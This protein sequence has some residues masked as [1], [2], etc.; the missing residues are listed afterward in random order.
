MTVAFYLHKPVPVILSD[1]LVTYSTDTTGFSPSSQDFSNFSPDRAA[2]LCS[3][4]Y[5]IDRETMFA[6]AGSEKDI[7]TFASSIPGEW[8]RRTKYERPVHG[9]REVDY[10]LNGADGPHG[11]NCEV[12]VA[13]EC[14][15]DE[16]FFINSYASRG[17]NH[18]IDTT[19]FGTCSAIGSGGDAIRQ[20]VEQEDKHVHHAPRSEI[21]DA[22]TILGRLN[23]RKLFGKLEYPEKE[24]WGGIMEAHYKPPGQNWQ[25]PPTFL[26]V[27]LC[28]EGEKLRFIGMDHKMIIHTQHVGGGSS[29]KLVLNST[30]GKSDATDHTWHIR[31]VIPN[32]FEKQYSDDS[33]AIPTFC[34]VTNVV[35][36]NGERNMGHHTMPIENFDGIT[37]NSS[38]GVVDFNSVVLGEFVRE[39]LI[40]QGAIETIKGLGSGPVK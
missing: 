10:Y 33:E 17:R 12:L 21:F 19:R 3:K 9:I 38:S 31:P 24:T 23:G 25:R 15:T 4:T 11:W 36:L 13:T 32:Q 2:T 35:V 27:S 20:W 7:L 16:G 6:F 26:Y 30:L 28:Y 22:L 39:L 18:L 37:V 8:A 29:L 34:T 14:K 40:R 1:C 5:Q